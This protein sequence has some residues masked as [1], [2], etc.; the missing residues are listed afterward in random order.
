MHVQNFQKELSW[1]IRVLRG[2]PKHP[3]MKLP[4]RSAAIGAMIDL[5]RP[6]YRFDILSLRDPMPGIRI[7]TNLVRSACQAI[8][9]PLQRRKQSGRVLGHARTPITSENL[10]NHESLAGTKSLEEAQAK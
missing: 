9:G 3:V 1:I 6:S 8:L 4:K 10:S 5:L 7:M 2:A